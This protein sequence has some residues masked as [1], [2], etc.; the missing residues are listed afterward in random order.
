MAEKQQQKQQDQQIFKK[1]VDLI[2]HEEDLPKFREEIFS[3]SIDVI[4]RLYRNYFKRSAL[5]RVTKIYE[6]Q[7]IWASILL[8]ETNKNINEI[9]NFLSSDAKQ[10]APAFVREGPSKTRD[11]LNYYYKNLSWVTIWDIS[12]ETISEERQKKWNEL[13]FDEF[14]LVSSDSMHWSLKIKYI[15]EES[16]INNK[17]ENLAITFDNISKEASIWN[18]DSNEFY[19]DHKHDLKDLKNWIK[20]EKEK[21]DDICPNCCN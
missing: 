17:I 4:F 20:F 16:V 7:L 18:C 13:E 12:K 2:W 14:S 19:C 15:L 21:K 6:N 10:P 1:L 11:I 9:G 5:I 3:L 8:H